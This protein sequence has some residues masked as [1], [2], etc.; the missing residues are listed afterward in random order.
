MSTTRRSG[1]CRCSAS[2]SVVTRGSFGMLFTPVREI[3]SREWFSLLPTPEYIVF[4]GVGLGEGAGTLF[5]VLAEAAFDDLVL[6][7]VFEGPD[8][9]PRV[10]A[11]LTH[12]LVAVERALE[13]LDHVL[14]ANLLHALLEAAPGLLGDAPPPR[15]ASR[16]VGP[17]ELEERVHV[18]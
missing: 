8:P 5:I 13:P 17:G 16:D 18:G 1:S 14:G 7:V 10:P 6:E 4:A 9:G 15:G 2:H 11:E 12:E 3:A